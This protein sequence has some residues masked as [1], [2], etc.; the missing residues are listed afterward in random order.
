MNKPLSN[1][2][3]SIRDIKEDN[4][5]ERI[6]VT[7]LPITAEQAI[8]LGQALI[9]CRETGIDFIKDNGTRHVLQ[10]RIIEG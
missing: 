6:Y 8:D 10:F 5:A 4:D 7:T 1:F 2:E 9:D 3:S